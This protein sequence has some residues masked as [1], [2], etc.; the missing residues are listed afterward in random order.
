ML[1][2]GDTALE[3]LSSPDYARVLRSTRVNVHA[4]LE[5]QPDVFHT[6]GPQRLLSLT[7]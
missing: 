5:L 4:L 3:H 6:S 1:G 7:R 2:P